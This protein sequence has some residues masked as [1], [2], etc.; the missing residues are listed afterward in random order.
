MAAHK[1]PFATAFI[2][3]QLLSPFVSNPNSV[4]TWKK[5]RCLLQWAHTSAHSESYSTNRHPWLPRTA[6]QCC[7]T[8]AVCH[9]TEQKQCATMKP[10]C[11]TRQQEGRVGKTRTWE[12]C[13]IKGQ[14]WCRHWSDNCVAHERITVVFL[15]S[16]HPQSVNADSSIE[17]NKNKNY[18]YVSVRV[19]SRCSELVWQLLSSLFPFSYHTHT[20]SMPLFPVCFEQITDGPTGEKT[21][22]KWKRTDNKRMM[23]LGRKWKKRK[24]RT[25]SKAGREE[26]AENNIIR[27]ERWRREGEEGNEG[28]C[29]SS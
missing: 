27:R 18:M 13:R 17:T 4:S 25:D 28:E 3:L 15:S 6:G 19:L 12:R 9:Q 24:I 23:E 8:A 14:L 7:S 11:Q 20:Q 21:S 26:A 16:C 29:Q 5:N 2:F 10:R 1:L 22:A